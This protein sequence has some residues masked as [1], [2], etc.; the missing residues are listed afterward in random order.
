M[1]FRLTKVLGW[2]PRQRRTLLIEIGMQNAGLGSIL[3]TAHLGN[4]A[5]IPSAFYTVLCVITIAPGLTF[6]RR[7]INV[8]RPAKL[9]IG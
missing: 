3:V 4:T 8:G 2:P 5:A 9:V 7:F 6:H 1:A